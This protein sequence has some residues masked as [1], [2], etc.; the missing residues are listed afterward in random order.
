MV[1][2]VIVHKLETSFSD[3]NP[4]K[5]SLPKAVV[6]ML[7]W[8]YDLIK[9]KISIVGHYLTFCITGKELG[10]HKRDQKP[11]VF[12]GPSFSSSCL[13]LTLLTGCKPASSVEIFQ[14]LQ[15][16]TYPLSSC[17]SFSIGVCFLLRRRILFSS[18]LSATTWTDDC[19]NF[20]AILVATTDN[21]WKLCE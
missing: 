11:C 10:G 1:L 21:Q 3:P 20:D 15:P 9:V 7:V 6:L 4:S 17:L 12:S 2:S 8:F 5:L 16:C 18:A 13:P 19:G 14:I